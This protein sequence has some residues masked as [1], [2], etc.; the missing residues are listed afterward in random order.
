MFGKTLPGSCPVLNFCFQR[1]FYF[2]IDSISLLE[3][4]ISKLFLSSNSFGRLYVYRNLSISSR[5]SRLLVYNCSQYSRII[6]F[7]SVVFTVFFLFNSLYYLGSFFSLLGEPGQRLVNFVYLIKQLLVLLIFSITFKSQFISSFL[8]NFL[9]S[10]DF[11]GC[12]VLFLTLVRDRL[13]CLFDFFLFLDEGLYCY[14]LP[15]LN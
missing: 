9:P 11:W 8:I 4:G 3:I 6:L 13:C 2:I 14:E 1:G 12:L 5:L 10:A 15:S 7:I